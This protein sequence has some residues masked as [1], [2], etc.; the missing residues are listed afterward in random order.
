MKILHGSLACLLVLMMSTTGFSQFYD[1]SNMSFGKNRVQFDKFEWQYYRFK[2]Y[3]TYFYTGGKD[4]AIYASK[5]ARKH[6]SE[7]EDFLNFYDHQK[8]R[9]IIY[10]KYHH[11]KQSNIG[12]VDE[13]SNLG[14]VNK[15]VGTKVFTYFEGDH[16]K[17]EKEIRMGTAE[18]LLN[19]FLYGGD[20]RNF[21]R[22]PEMYKMPEWFFSGLVSYLSE[23]INS[24]IHDK[25]SDGVLSGRYRKLVQLEGEEARYAGYSIWKYIEDTY[26]RSVITNILYVTQINKDVESGFLYVLGISLKEMLIEWEFY[27]ENKYQKDRIE[28]RMPEE[29]IISKRIRKKWVYT[30]LDMDPSG[31]YYAYS[32]NRKGKFKLYIYDTQTGKRT[33]IFR[34]GIKL[35]RTPHYLYPKVA[36]HPTGEILAFVYQKKGKLLMNFY[37]VENKETTSRKIFLM[38]DILDISYSPDGKQMLFS[39][40][41]EGQSDIYLYNIPGNTQNKI[42]DDPFDDVNPVFV[43]SSRDIMFSS[44]RVSELVDPQVKEPDTSNLQYDLF[45]YKVGSDAEVFSR[46]TN[47]ENI[48]EVDPFVYRDGD[49]FYISDEQGVRNLYKTAFDSAITSIDTTIH[50]RYY[51]T[52]DEVSNFRRGV[53]DF[54]GTGE[55]GD[56]AFLYFKDGKYHMKGGNLRMTEQLTENLGP[57]AEKPID[58][59]DAGEKS[60]EE[61]KQVFKNPPK[62]GEVDIHDYQFEHK[63]ET[64][65]TYEKE[66]IV[67]DKLEESEEDGS[68]E[69]VLPQQRNYNLSFLQDESILQL[70]NS[71]LN[72]QY[73][74]YGPPYQNSGLGIMFLLGISDLFEDYKVFG[75]VRYSVQSSEYMLSYQNLRRRLDKEYYVGL[76]NYTTQRGNLEYKNRTTKGALSL[77]YPFT[78]VSSMHFG[79]IG[80]RDRLIPQASSLA[81]LE[82]DIINDYW[83]TY[84]MAYVYDNTRNKAINI[85]YGTRYK[86]FAEYYQQINNEQINMEV[87]GFDV[88]HYQKIHRELILLTRI[89]GSSS[90][91]KGKIVYYLGGV[92]NWI[93]TDRF[94]FAQ[95]IDASGQNFKFQALGTNMRGFKQNVRNG[96]SFAVANAELRWPVIRYFYRKPMRS[97]F[98]RNFQ[99]IGFGDIGSAWNGAD[100]YSDE[101]DQTEKQINNGPVIIVLTN[102]NEPFVGS[103]GAGFRMVLLGYFV[104]FDWAWG[105]ENG[106]IRDEMFHFSL[107]LDL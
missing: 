62:E 99:L 69:F 73:Q 3:E 80:R 13:N 43:N 21:I 44:N 85:K 59:S 71:F 7:I 77:K 57:P 8:I 33:K 28:I 27:L 75:G 42:T 11:Y 38:E 92:D 25:I 64:S 39:G 45:S 51:Y 48:N 53:I 54:T 86:I 35:D 56:E 2:N 55:K 98:L 102:S 100:P 4:L 12:I 50:Y 23:D 47:T 91:G 58:R 106:V 6:I 70:N 30:L 97:T 17:F 1:G 24:E 72:Q 95:A 74:P 31:R 40:V 34:H 63:K 52:K 41:Y 78:E 67:F 103:I 14:G 89:G 26:G 49:I 32:R 10:N 37:E 93:D 84:K 18:V 87:V 104:R 65:F 61:M 68:E 90:F 96:S 20:W 16:K 60:Y 29:E 76:V 82:A 79:F 88:R 36:W 101:N 83:G 81:G 107:S 66:V 19:N 9:Y 94:S 15:V 46:V 22:N 105:I 5:S